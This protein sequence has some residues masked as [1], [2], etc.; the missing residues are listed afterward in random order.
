MGFT[1]YAAALSFLAAVASAETV[2]VTPHD[3][4]SS[5]VGVLGCKIDTNRVA[6][7]PGAVDCNNF[8][9][10]LSHEGRSLN[11][12]RIDTSGGAHDVSYDTWNMLVTGKSATE[13]PTAGGGVDMDYE[14]LDPSECA[15]LFHTDGNK[16]PLSG[17]N[18]MGFLAECL[19]QPDSWV[20]NN[21]VLYNIVDPVCHWGY[22]EV[23][24]LD[25]P[26]ANQATC[27][28]QLG[29]T[30]ALT[31]QPVYDIKY[32]FGEVVVASTGEV[33]NSAAAATAAKP[34]SKRAFRRFYA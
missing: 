9:I 29:S 32:P 25:W 1:T 14:V 34:K 11:I 30:V 10:R 4:Y 19:N 6:Y 7:W 21:Y 16:M 3:S 18:S 2:S 26:A 27:P 20:A 8:C 15:D 17:A 33:A 5:S 28:H 13:E 24:D 22:N 23:C 12:L 31:D